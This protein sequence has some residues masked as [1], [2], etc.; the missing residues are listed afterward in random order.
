MYQVLTTLG[1]NYETEGNIEHVLQRGTV[2][3]YCI[4]V[5]HIIQSF[6]AAHALNNAG[7]IAGSKSVHTLSSIIFAMVLYGICRVLLCS[8]LAFRISAI[9]NLD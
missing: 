2:S 8:S 9:L 1:T 4:E 3:K 6:L 5:P 7:V